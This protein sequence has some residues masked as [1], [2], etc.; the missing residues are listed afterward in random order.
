VFGKLE[1]SD[2]IGIENYIQENK[3][4][5]VY[6]HQP[7]KD[8]KAKI[9]RGSFY[10]YIDEQK[11]EHNLEGLFYF[12]N[13]KALLMHFKN[14]S[15]LNNLNLLKAIKM[16]RP[17]YIKGETSVV[18]KLYQI[19]YRT[20][21]TT[22]EDK[23]YLMVYQ[24]GIPPVPEFNNNQYELILSVES[25][26]RPLE[27]DISFFMKAEK[28]F[29][30]NVQ[31]FHDLQT[32]VNLQLES[33]KIVLISCDN[34]IIAQGFVENETED[35]GIIS[36]IYVEEK[37]RKQQLGRLISVNL[38]EKLL[39]QKKQAMLFVLKNNLLAINLYETIGYQRVKEYTILTIEFK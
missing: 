5:T 10:G 39:K 12:S 11:N 35:N 28:A 25:L 2:V 22:V 36:G 30:R 24:G 20:L 1:Q 34:Q 33:R 19:L 21:R 9:D 8:F 38:T 31:A 6:L 27:R 3:M 4:G 37:H 13:T 18:N 17:Q 15:V 7:F 23:S 26:K 16:H 14:D 32:Q 29:G